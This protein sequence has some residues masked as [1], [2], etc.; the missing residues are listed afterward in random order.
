MPIPGRGCGA[1]FPPSPDWG[2]YFIYLS[3]W[4]ALDLRSVNL[5]GHF[6]TLAI[7]EQFYL[8]WPVVIRFTPR[9]WLTPLFLSGIVAAFVLRLFLPLPTRNTFC[10]M[11]GLLLGALAAWL[12]R[13]KPEHRLQQTAK[14]MARATPLLVVAAVLLEARP[15][16]GPLYSLAFT[17]WC[18]A[19]FGLILWIFVQRRDPSPAGWIWRTSGMRWLGKYSY[20]IYVF[21]PMLFFFTAAFLGPMT[22][23]SALPFATIASGISFAVAGF[24]YNCF[25][26][27]FLQAKRAFD[28]RPGALRLTQP[29]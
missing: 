17:C 5:I 28:L 15:P 25:E 9:R 27:R 14:W 23:A 12:I 29:I 19:S 13:S 7:E 11:D 4:R 8:V 22:A 20:G 18:A 1:P 6:W 21:H 10:R 16:D 3:N 26:V 24:S 2:L